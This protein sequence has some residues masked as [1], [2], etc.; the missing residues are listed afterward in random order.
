MWWLMYLQLRFGFIL[1]TLY[2]RE[3]GFLPATTAV[4]ICVTDKNTWS[5]PMPNTKVNDM[6]TWIICFTCLI[7]FHFLYL[8]KFVLDVSIMHLSTSIILMIVKHIDKHLIKTVGHNMNN[9]DNILQGVPS[10]SIYSTVMLGALLY[11][12]SVC[13]HITFLYH[14]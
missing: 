14:D 3:L 10:N 7:I 12:L 4:S 6:V 1:S 11:L 2:S 13:V 5:I 8:N 9:N